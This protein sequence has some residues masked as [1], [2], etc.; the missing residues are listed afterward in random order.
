[1]PEDI[2]LFIDFEN[3]RYSMLNIQRR[4]PDPQ[5][6]I[7][8][9]RRYGTVMVARAYADWS[10][11]PEPFKGSLTAAMIDRVDCPAKQRDRIRM[12]TFHYTSGNTPSGALGAP[13]YTAEQG[14]GGPY[15]RQWPSSVTGNSGPF[16]AINAQSMSNGW[17]IEQESSLPSQNGLD[18]NLLPLDESIPEEDNFGS[19]DY[20]QRESYRQSLS[21]QNPY[22][23]PPTGPLGQSSTGPLGY[24]STGNTG[25]MPAITGNTNNGTVV[26]STVVQST[27]DLNMLMDII[28]TVFDRPTI[29]TFV[30]MTGDKDFTR[31][32]ARLKLRL[33]KTVIVVGIPGTVSRDLIS[34][35]NQFVPLVPNGTTGA[36]G[37]GNTGTLPSINSATFSQGAPTGNTTPMPA[38]NYSANTSQ[39]GTQFQQVPY[40]T[41]PMDVLDPQ[42]LQFLDYIDRNWSWR[43]IIGVSNFI[44]DPL[45][46]K[47]RFRGRLTRESARELL[48]TCIQQSI[49]LL[50]TDPTGAE[51]LRLNRSHPG[52]DEVL[53]QFV[54]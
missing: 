45:N 5:E 4:E 13:T 32:S 49:L 47:N 20:Q 18:D 53:K 28:E 16:P 34:S 26:Q 1:M 27:V 2:A 38:I 7:A 33:N 11:Q 23:Q 21:Y 14:A 9:A 35:A 41:P 6:L 39:S 8:V 52:V 29:S 31:I 36:M 15:P 10:R 19:S 22:S 44:G 54:R 40:G 12:G 43:T 24:P 50:H 3:I 51:D 17:P 25:H 37:L 46:P 48:N 30:L 42:F